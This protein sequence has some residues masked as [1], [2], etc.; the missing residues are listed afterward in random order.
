M[1]R[2]IGKQKQSVLY[3]LC[4]LAIIVLSSIITQT[5]GLLCFLLSLSFLTVGLRKLSSSNPLICAKNYL[6]NL[7]TKQYTRLR[8]IFTQ[9]FPLHWHS[10][11]GPVSREVSKL[12]KQEGLS[13]RHSPLAPGRSLAAE[14][15]CQINRIYSPLGM[16][17]Q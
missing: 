6:M 16:E 10:F 4:L 5:S 3:V 2:A 8:K 1:S 11:I 12:L 13:C 7:T 17:T 15:V 14:S 9:Q